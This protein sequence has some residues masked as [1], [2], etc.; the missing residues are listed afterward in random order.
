MA[1]RCKTPKRSVNVE[2]C[3]WLQWS[4]GK[5]KGNNAKVGECGVLRLAPVEYRQEKRE[6]CKATGRPRH[7]GPH[8]T[9]PVPAAHLSP[10]GCGLSWARPGATLRDPGEPAHEITPIPGVAAPQRTC[11]MA[12]PAPRPLDATR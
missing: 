11:R 6:Q 8:R 1:S 2:Y 4:T 10:T 7:P 5:R 12:P 9:K 3:G